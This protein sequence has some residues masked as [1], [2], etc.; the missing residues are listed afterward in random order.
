MSNQQIFDDI[1]HQ[2]SSEEEEEKEI[3]EGEYNNNKKHKYTSSLTNK[4]DLKI[5]ESLSNLQNENEINENEI[6]NNNHMNEYEDNEE[7]NSKEQETEQDY[8]IEN[9]NL[10]SDIDSDNNNDNDNNNSNKKN[11]NSNEEENSEDNKENENSEN[12][13]NNDNIENGN[14]E[15]NDDDEMNKQ[16]Y[17]EKGEKNDLIN[18]IY[19]NNKDENLDSFDNNCLRMHS[20]RPNPIPGS[21]KFTKRVSI[22]N[23][24]IEN[25]ENKKSNN[26]NNNNNNNLTNFTETIKTKIEGDLKNSIKINPSNNNQV[27][28]IYTHNSNIISLGELP[29]K[30]NIDVFE[31]FQVK[32]TNNNNIKEEYSINKNNK[33][34]EK[35]KE[36]EEAF[37]RTEELKR[38]K[39]KEEIE[40]NI[41]EEKE[42]EG[43]ENITEDEEENNQIQTNN[44]IINK[45]NIN[46]NDEKEKKDKVKEEVT[47]DEDEEE[48]NKN[49]KN[50]IKKEVKHKINVRDISI[51]LLEQ[52][53]KTNESIYSSRQSDKNSL[54]NNT[55]SNKELSSSN[56]K[57]III[58]LEDS[59]SNN[60]PSNVNYSSNTYSSSE[61]KKQIKN[62]Y[63][64]INNHNSNNTKKNNIKNNELQNIKKNLY[65]DKKPTKNI[66]Y[67]PE[68]YSFSPE[69]SQKSREICQKN[70]KK[71]GPNMP[72]GDLLYN[73]ANIKKEK[74]N[75]I[76]L[77]ENNI[78][79]SNANIKKININSYNLAIERMN[80]KINNT[81]NKYSINGKLSIVGITLSLYDLNIIIELLK[82]KIINNDLDYEEL[83]TIIESINEKENKKLEETEFLEQFWFMMNPSL[84]QFINSQIFFELL[85]ILLSSNNNA[86]DLTN[87]VEKILEKYNINSEQENDNNSFNDNLYLSPLR[88]IKYK[89][90]ELWPLTKIIKKFLNLKQ[91]IKTYQKKD[92]QK[93]NDYNNIIKEREK[94]LTFQPDMISNTFFYKH[95]KYDYNR[96]N[97]FD[98]KDSSKINSNHKRQ[99]HDFDKVYERF[100]AD[101]K[102][103]EK[104]LERLRKIKN[105]KELKMCTNV[106]KINK[107]IPKS[108]DKIVQKKKKKETEKMKESIMLKKSKSTNNINLSIFQKLYETKK[109]NYQNVQNNQKL[110][111]NCTF[112]PQ[113]TARGDIFNKTF[114]N[115]RKPKGFENYV[116][117]N[118]SLLKKKEYDKKLEEDKK[119]GKNYEKIQKMKIKPFNITDLN[120]NTQKKKKNNYVCNTT[121]FKEKNRDF[122][123]EKVGSIIDDVYITIDIKTPNGLLKPLKIYNKNAKDTMDFVN[124]FCKIYSINDENKKIILK[125]VIQYKNIFFGRNI[126]DNNNNNKRDRFIM[127]EDLE[128]ITNTNT[129]TNSNND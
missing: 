85:K 44:D 76:C 15:N 84:T 30:D 13:K 82:N 98:I 10:Y 117:R 103:Q 105:E 46:E 1:M 68:Q 2:F 86:K 43:K 12:D 6:Q 41:K 106:P 119:Y 116:E 108:P 60:S 114:S 39:Y 38:K 77:T 20:F 74:F 8:Y 29:N 66:K 107:Y 31:S 59:K 9:Q 81:I 121:R 37:L 93:S 53:K 27:N 122:L 94:D 64:L 63:K 24:V 79:K 40:S 80:K 109:R 92:Y 78:I 69:I 112:K 7:S 35:E 97:S 45:K 111:E 70:N 22:N 58:P 36:E 3:E 73:E 17:D 95:S 101:K 126:N 54:N 120:E 50:G 48:N 104:T 56:K 18:D 32:N 96:D 71:K 67:E 16:L 88:D 65:N 124:E 123:G 127:N 4:S 100:M 26:I 72:I 118:R 115:M 89:K 110:D 99:K 28:P 49:M 52:Y 102:L 23:N 87:R 19:H 61:N 125:K 11:N 33:E 83:Q 57:N 129:N 14:N 55:D 21:P 90:E 42:E 51:K 34:D 25:N 62:S 128:T 75:K 47:E 113:L 91:N 5:K